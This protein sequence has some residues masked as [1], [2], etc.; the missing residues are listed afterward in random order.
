[1]SR[2]HDSAA[3]K[4]ATVIRPWTAGVLAGLVLAVAVGCGG[5]GGTETTPPLAEGPGGIVVIALDG[6]RY[7]FMGYAGLKDVATPNLDALAAE[8]V[9]FDWAFSQSPDATPSMASFLSG[10]YPTTSGVL[11][12]S[13]TLIPDILTLPEVLRD[14]GY[15][16]GAFV[17]AGTGADADGFAQGFDTFETLPEPGA[18]G[19]EW[20]EAQA[21]SPFFAMISGWAPASFTAEAVDDTSGVARPDGFQERLIESLDRAEKGEAVTFTDADREYLLAAYAARIAILDERVG[22][23]MARFRALGLDRN[24]T[25]VVLS[26]CGRDLGQHDDP[27]NGSVYA[28]TTHVPLLIR[29][30]G[31]ANAH[32][33]DKVVELVDVMPTLVEGAEGVIPGPVQGSS[34]KPI[35]DGTSNPPYIAFGESLWHNGQRFAVLGGYQL[36]VESD[37]VMPPKLFYLPEDP[38]ALKDV[39]ADDEARAEVLLAHIEAW[40]KLIAASSYNP[41]LRT[42]DLDDATLEQL[43]SLGYIQ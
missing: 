18:T 38:A 22:E 4:N 24:A 43:K 40:S 11:E 35:I 20:I 1:M 26:T 23:F 37:Q 25:L 36:V 32:V 28:P 13:D 21:G 17:Q 33:V 19:L 9:R 27:M 41:D 5:G 16:T 39:A 14:A 31:G 8:S 2:L 12:S 3:L 29:Y 15:R 10:L 6:V 7:D 34:L 42:E 30:A